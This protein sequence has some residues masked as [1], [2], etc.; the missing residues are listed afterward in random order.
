MKHMKTC[1]M[2]ETTSIDEK[3]VS[4]STRDD[5]IVALSFE[6]NKN[7]FYLPILTAQK[8]KNLLGYSASYCSIKEI[9][10]RNFEK[11]GELEVL[12]LSSNQIE[13]ILNDTFE[14][15]ESLQKLYLGD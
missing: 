2:A 6:G 12:G 11:L 4:I 1:F 13:F 14:D 7:I 15:L 8:F 5:S 9:S 3:S 10:K